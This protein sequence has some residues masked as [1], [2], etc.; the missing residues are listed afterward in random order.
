MHKA[1]S[2]TRA[3]SLLWAACFSA[4][5]LSL[6]PPSLKAQE[7]R[8]A[9]MAGV[10]GAPGDKF[11]PYVAVRL[12]R[13][14]IPWLRLQAEFAYAQ[15]LYSGLHG[16]CIAEGCFWESLDLRA[17]TVQLPV[18]VVALPFR[19][20]RTF[21]RAGA[22][23]GLRVACTGTLALTPTDPCVGRAAT[24]FGYLGAVGGRF[25]WGRGDLWIEARFTQMLQPLAKLRT[26]AGVEREYSAQ[27][28]SLLVALDVPLW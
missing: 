5:L 23:V 25:P 21:L 20:H 12:G 4:G 16:G 27:A 13:V 1:S 8:A 19:D 15:E 6:V 14:L 10:S 2:A 24:T 22:T 9:A 17:H 18:S 7:W 11:G 28:F 26:P 3:V